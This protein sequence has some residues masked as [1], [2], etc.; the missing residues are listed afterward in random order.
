[1]RSR[2]RSADP[3]LPKHVRCT[4]NPGGP[5]HCV[6]FGEVLTTSGW[7]NIED[8]IIGEEV[9]SVDKFGK[10]V[11]KKVSDTISIPF[12]G[13][14]VSRKNQMVFTYNHRL[15][16]QTASGIEIRHFEE[17]PG[18]C[19]IVRAASSLL[20]PVAD[21]SFTVPAFNSRKTR[22]SQPDSISQKDYSELMGWFLSEGHT[23][24]RD[25]EFG[26]SQLKEP[27]RTQIKDLLIR[28]GFSFREHSLGFSVSSPKWWN[29]FKQFGK[30][31]DK[32]IPRDFF[33][34]G[35][36][37]VFFKSLMDGD[38]HW[39]SESSGT[40]YTISKQLAN[41]FSEICV[42]LGLS[43]VIY[44]RQR[45][46]RDGPSYE[47][48]FT[49]RKTTELVTGNH[50]YNTNTINNSVNVEKYEYKGQVYC[51]TVPETETFFIRQNGYVWLSGA[52]G[53]AL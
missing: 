27:Q 49:S 43:S 53:L 19:N 11:V 38:G 36:L 40:Y 4:T 42:R 24:D 31:R 52:W 37:S 14:M 16:M 2:L 15:P 12:D 48:H 22:L 21:K 18:Q 44:T 34:V 9:L 30:S 5:G 33:Q 41:D 45:E 20:N 10:L 17:L 26:I 7:K 25:K 23:L 39:G 47:I 46:N 50:I 1:M 13:Q 6:P 28:C 3:T 29:Y 32:H 35:D 51:L 8:V